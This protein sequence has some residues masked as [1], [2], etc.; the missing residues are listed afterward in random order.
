MD[1][2]IHTPKKD[3]EKGHSSGHVAA[4][5]ATASRK[6]K[7]YVSSETSLAQQLNSLKRKIKV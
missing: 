3:A 4:E 2:G 7:R 6:K 1:T 5:T